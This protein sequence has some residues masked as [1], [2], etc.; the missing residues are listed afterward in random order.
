MP[1]SNFWTNFPRYKA[2]Q[3]Q[4][5]LIGSL[6]TVAVVLAIGISAALLHRQL[7]LFEESS[8]AQP[9]RLAIWD[10]AQLQR[11]LLSLRGAME[12]AFASN[13][14]PDR[15]HLQLQLDLAFSRMDI[16]FRGD[17]GLEVAKIP[18]SI[19]RLPTIHIL[20]KEVDSEFPAFLN[21]PK[22]H[23]TA[24]L[25][26]INSAILISQETHSLAWNDLLIWSDRLKTRLDDVETQTLLL[27]AAFIL[28][29]VLLVIV[30]WRN[31]SIRFHTVYG[32][33]EQLE[34]SEERFR[35]LVESSMQG[36][37]VHRNFEVLY[38]NDAYLEM[39]GYTTPPAS[40]SE[41]ELLLGLPEPVREQ[42]RRNNEERMQ[43]KPVKSRFE[44]EIHRIDLKPLWV[45]MQANVVHWEGKPAVLLTLMDLTHTKLAE[46]SLKKAKETS[47]AISKAKSSF[48]ANMSHELRTPM[49]SVIGFADLIQKEIYGPVPEDIREAVEE[50]QASGHQLLGL[51]NDVLD[52]SKIESGH[53]TLRIAEH[54]P[55]ECVMA[56]VRRMNALAH[57]RGIGLEIDHQDN[58]HASAMFDDQR[59]TQVLTNLIGNAI[60]F[61]DKGS[62]RVGTK[63]EEGVLT[64]WVHDTGIGIPH[65]ALDGLFDEFQQ[66]N[67]DGPYERTGAGL[68]LAI[69]KGIVEGHGGQIWV[70]SK[71]GLGSTFWFSLPQ[72]R[73]VS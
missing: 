13:E 71:V 58:N 65:D 49:T 8:K 60:K 47:D 17:V 52:I 55:M 39:K 41:I 12:V 48:L 56:V 43:S 27:D 24:L 69:V 2:L 66:V 19:N 73:G 15:N 46:Q 9:E 68:G 20:L 70:D 44:V 50:I 63:C 72:Q 28:L 16:L 30:I 31:F 54:S 23:G 40:L 59:I 18:K 64:F 21:D 26:R 53:L 33:M 38:V 35:H 14:P 5:T 61:T 57:E 32:L 22:A 42:M 25:Q 37:V 62:I 34:H 45:E 67:G 10:L 51:I 36:I 3:T 6:L 29:V 1:K 7:F 4:W 11:Q